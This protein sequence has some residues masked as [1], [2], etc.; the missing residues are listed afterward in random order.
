MQCK[1]TDQFCTC[2]ETRVG[3]KIP[4]W[5]TKCAHCETSHCTMSWVQRQITPVVGPIGEITGTENSGETG[6]IRDPV[7]HADAQSL[8]ERVNNTQC[9][10]LTHSQR[11]PHD[12]LACLVAQEASADAI[13]RTDT[14]TETMSAPSNSTCADIA[15]VVDHPMFAFV[16][17]ANPG[18]N[19]LTKTV[20]VGLLMRAILPRVPQAA[21][22]T[23]SV[24]IGGGLTVSNFGYNRVLSVYNSTD[25]VVRP[26][27]P[28]DGCRGVA[29]IDVPLD[30]PVV[31][32]DFEPSASNDQVWTVGLRGP[33]QLKSR[34]SSPYR[35]QSCCVYRKG[36]ECRGIPKCDTLMRSYIDD[37]K[38]LLNESI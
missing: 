8:I 14:N 11:S 17:H 20:S 35:Q 30:A 27:Q 2:R 25:A 15:D 3:H 38:G 9:L 31:Q 13:Q 16:S 7:W 26:L 10:K 6:K 37:V 29:N 33:D 1:N 22:T 5:C 24:D 21:T 4:Y 23:R 12:T 19:S 18:S 32:M 36:Q 34:Y 28:D